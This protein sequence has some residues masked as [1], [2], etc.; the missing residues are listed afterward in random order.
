MS[1]TADRAARWARVQEVFHAALEQS[2][3]VALY[4]AWNRP[5]DAA[6]YRGGQ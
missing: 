4:E 2:P 3:A 1:E 5:E 6:R